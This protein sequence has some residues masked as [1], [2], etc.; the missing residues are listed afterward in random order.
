MSCKCPGST[1]TARASAAVAIATG[2]EYNGTSLNALFAQRRNLLKPPFLK[3]VVEILRF[4]R[5]APKLLRSDPHQISLGDYLRREAFSS[6]FVRNYI[7]PMGAAV[8]STRPEDML[9]FP[10]R[11]FV[12]FFA[13][14]GFLNVADRPIWRVVRGGS[15]EYVK[16]LTARFGHS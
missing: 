10:A 2:L 6:Y 9:D 4:N 16:R 13:N 3:M 7:V 11:F 12:E 15:R 5:E 1:A 8:W 14:H